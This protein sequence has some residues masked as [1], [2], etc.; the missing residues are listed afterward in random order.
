MGPTG[1]PQEMSPADPKKS[2][3]KAIKS[4]PSWW[5]R[6]EAGW[7]LPRDT[8]RCQGGDA[9]GCETLA[10]KRWLLILLKVL[11][12]RRRHGHLGHSLGH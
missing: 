12:P 9:T 2:I 3:K 4:A 6:V 10:L 1:C 7:V 8:G 11:I 5:P